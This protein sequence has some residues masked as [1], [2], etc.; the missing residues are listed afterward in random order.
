MLYNL[1]H[2]LDTYDTKDV[3]SKLSLAIFLSLYYYFVYGS[4]T[5]H[6]AGVS[7]S[8]IL[9]LSTISYIIYNNY[10]YR[11]YTKIWQNIAVSLVSFLF[12]FFVLHLLFGDVNAG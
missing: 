12:L 3:I 10:R 4:E 5:M 11:K 2:T 6:W 8:G 9:S 1:K 7:V